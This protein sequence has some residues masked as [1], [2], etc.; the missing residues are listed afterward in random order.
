VQDLLLRGLDNT[1]QLAQQVLAFE[2]HQQ[3]DLG[4]VEG[5]GPR[6]STRP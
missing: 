2:D 4:A 3:D 5:G 1:P 6:F